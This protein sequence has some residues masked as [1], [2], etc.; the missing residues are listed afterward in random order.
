MDDRST[1]DRARRLERRGDPRVDCGSA[2]AGPIIKSAPHVTIMIH[3][4][5][6]FSTGRARVFGEALAEAG[7]GRS[8]TIK[9]G[10]MPGRPTG[11][12]GL[13]LTASP[14]HGP[15]EGYDICISALIAILS[16]ILL[17]R[18]FSRAFLS[19][20]LFRDAVPHPYTFRDS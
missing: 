3:V 10:S 18:I 14:L 6:D 11:C 1:F 15:H 7:R 16:L 13:P 20:I 12:Q 9:L 5:G 19:Q 17:C 2:A 8:A 4:P